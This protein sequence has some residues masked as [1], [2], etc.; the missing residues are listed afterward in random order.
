MRAV[1]ENIDGHPWFIS[2]GGPKSLSLRRLLCCC[3]PPAVVACGV[4]GESNPS[5]V[6]HLCMLVDEHITNRYEY[7]EGWG[8]MMGHRSRF[9]YSILL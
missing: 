7:E 4:V 2:P 1:N 5:N 9:S 3:R 8:R 6:H